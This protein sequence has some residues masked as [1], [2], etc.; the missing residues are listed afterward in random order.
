VNDRNGLKSQPLAEP[1][2]PEIG[3]DFGS[4]FRLRQIGMGE[5]LTP[6]KRLHFSSVFAFPTLLWVSE[7][8][9]LR[10][11]ADRRN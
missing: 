2:D 7:E 9:I 11:S 4:A 1:L 5:K 10:L 3:A 8:L 6:P